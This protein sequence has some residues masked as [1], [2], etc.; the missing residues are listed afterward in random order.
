MKMENV[1]EKK[2][3]EE[4]EEGTKIRRNVEGLRRRECRPNY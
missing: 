2:I 4:I 3:K 1:R